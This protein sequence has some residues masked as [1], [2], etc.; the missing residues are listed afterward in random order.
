VTGCALKTRG[1]SSRPKRGKL[2]PYDH[3][4]VHGSRAWTSMKSFR[5]KEFSDDPPDPGRNNEWDFRH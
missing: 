2:L 5:V 3:F 4:L 1:E